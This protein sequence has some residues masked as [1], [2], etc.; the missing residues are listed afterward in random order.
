MPTL[1]MVTVVYLSSSMYSSSWLMGSGSW[2]PVNSSSSLSSSSSS[3]S[4][5]SALPLR[6]RSPFACLTRRSTSSTC[7]ARS[8]FRC[9][10]SY[11]SSLVS[12][13]IKLQFPFPVHLSLNFLRVSGNSVLT[14]LPPKS[15]LL[16]LLALCILLLSELYACNLALVKACE[17][18]FASGGVKRYVLRGR[19]SDFA[20]LGGR[21]H[22][23]VE[24]RGGELCS[25]TSK[26]WEWGRWLGRKRLRSLGDSRKLLQGSERSGKW[27]GFADKTLCFWKKFQS[28][29]VSIV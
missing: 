23:E 25:W 29:R 24:L 14:Y 21:R 16:L 2:N 9:S 15:Q 6:S 4:E 17:V 28:A 19:H 1:S 20:L 8:I 11:I 12:P 26:L 13:L 7:F 5:E 3:S 18:F 10:R 27:E 22:G